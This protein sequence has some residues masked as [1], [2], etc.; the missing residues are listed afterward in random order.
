MRLTNGA[1]SVLYCARS[2]SP[3]AGVHLSIAIALSKDLKDGDGVLPIS[4]VR[5]NILDQAEFVPA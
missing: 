5:V 4:E 1:D 3:L 2:H